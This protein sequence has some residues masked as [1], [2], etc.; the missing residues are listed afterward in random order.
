[1]GMFN[2]NTV[3]GLAASFKKKFKTIED[4]QRTKAKSLSVEANILDRKAINKRAEQNK[5][6]KEMGLAKRMSVKIDKFFSD[7]D[8]IDLPTESVNEP[9]T[10]N[11]MSNSDLA[12]RAKDIG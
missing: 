7:D 9:E 1:M 3:S 11:Q 4:A 12:L 2:E 5:A 10:K 6:E 8:S